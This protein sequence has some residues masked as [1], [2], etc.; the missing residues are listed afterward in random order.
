MHGIHLADLFRSLNEPSSRRGIAGGALV[1]VLGALGLAGA[2]AGKRRKKRR[3]RKRRKQRQQERRKEQQP[4]EPQPQPHVCQGRNACIG[5]SL[6]ARCSTDPNCF[7]FVTAVG[8][9]YC[10]KGNGVA[11]CQQCE[12]FP[13]RDCFPGGGSNCADFSCVEPC[14]V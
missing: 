7:C 2:D 9:P 12:Q 10:G 14:P 11:S 1:G 13:G 8:E 6:D 5:T 3:R 4:E